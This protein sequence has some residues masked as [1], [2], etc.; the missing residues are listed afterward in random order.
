MSDK[1]CPDCGCY[2]FC[3]EGGSAH[4]RHQHTVGGL[5]CLEA[6]LATANA[7]IEKLPKTANGV[8]AVP[9]MKLYPLHPIPDTEDDHG[10]VTIGVYDPETMEH[11]VHGYNDFRVGLNYSTPQ[12]AA[13]AA[14]KSPD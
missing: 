1:K 12:A 4:E 8:T 11:H 7:V 14:K 2:M 6:Q 5:H 13:E 3:F 10:I 9:G